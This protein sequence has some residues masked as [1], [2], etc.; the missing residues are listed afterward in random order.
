MRSFYEAPSYFEVIPVGGK[1]PVRE[2][3]DKLKQ[4]LLKAN[5]TM[6]SLTLDPSQKGTRLLVKL[7]RTVHIARVRQEQREQHRAARGQRSPRP[8]EMKRAR[9]PMPDGLLSG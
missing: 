5:I 9:M 1:I 8:P 2:V 3:A 4:P 6:F 7:R